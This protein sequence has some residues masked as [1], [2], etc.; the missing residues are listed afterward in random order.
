MGQRTA[1]RRRLAI[2]TTGVPTWPHDLVDSN[3]C[4]VHVVVLPKAD[5]G[6]T[7]SSQTSVGISISGDVGCKLLG[8]P[9]RIRLRP[10]RVL[11]AAVPK[12]SV[13]KDGNAGTREHNVGTASGSGNYRV[14][15]A[16][17]ETQPM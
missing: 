16:I 12:A 8:P 7:R 17:S 9:G 5:H 3:R 14:F 1:A 4:L 2:P 10:G 15:N 11:W 6:P 13:Y